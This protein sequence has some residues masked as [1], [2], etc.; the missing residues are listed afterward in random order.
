MLAN[1]ESK[2]YI[3]GCLRPLVTVSGIE[4]SAASSAL[5]VIPA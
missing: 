3:D 4:R 2:L 1:V 5:D